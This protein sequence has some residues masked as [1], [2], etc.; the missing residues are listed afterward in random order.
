ML[1]KWPNYGFDDILQLNI[2]HNDLISNT[3]ILLDVATGD[4]MMTVD[5]KQETKIIDVLASTNYQTHNNRQLSQIKGMLDHNTSDAI[6][7]QNK[8]LTQRVKTL[9]K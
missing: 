9:T 8:I 5:V 7:A 6:L 3:I 4:A 2:F 1:R